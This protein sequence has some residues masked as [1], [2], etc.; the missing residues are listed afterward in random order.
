MQLSIPMLFWVIYCGKQADGTD[1]AQ[2][3]MRGGRS[4]L[5]LDAILPPPA[6]DMIDD[7]GQDSVDAGET[8]CPQPVSFPMTKTGFQKFERKLQKRIITRQQYLEV[9]RNR[10]LGLFADYRQSVVAVEDVAW[11]REYNHIVNAP[12]AGS[13][14]NSKRTSSCPAAN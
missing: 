13:L 9:I 4:Y 2:T 5:H 6:E 10:A 12:A 11:L 8:Q 3:P 7:I 1:G 14:A